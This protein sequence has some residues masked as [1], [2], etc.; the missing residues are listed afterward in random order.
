MYSLMN[1][2]AHCL[3]VPR[4]V[5]ET[6]ELFSQPTALGNKPMMNILAFCEFT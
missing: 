5:K 4:L 2:W 1:L 6:G 3:E